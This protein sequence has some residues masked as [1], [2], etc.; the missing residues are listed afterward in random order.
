MLPRIILA[1]ATAAGI[2]FTASGSNSSATA[3][4]L[5]IKVHDA[6][7]NKPVEFCNIIAKNLPI[8]AL[9][10]EWGCAV[11]KAEPTTLC[12]TLLV[13]SVG[14]EKLM[15]ALTPETVNIDTLRIYLRP[16][17]YPLHEVT[18]KP[19]RKTKV[20]KKGKRHDGG[21]FM[22]QFKVSRGDC[23][24]W[25]AGTKGK[26]TWLTSIQ[27]QSW[28]YPDSSKRS[29]TDSEAAA[30][31][32]TGI[33]PLEQR[34]RMR[35]NIYDASTKSTKSSGIER[36]DYTN[37][38]HK[39]IIISYTKEQVIDNL[40]TYT[41]PEPILLPEKAL[42][43]IEILDEIPTD[44]MIIFK[45]NMFGRGIIFRNVNEKIWTKIPL[46]TPFTLIFLE[47]KL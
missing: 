17:E 41:L 31:G 45:N 44:E 34:M 15:V 26:R 42:V 23:F 35:V 7:T 37:I 6:E 3:D 39:P 12:D 43:E 38:L 25:E 22:G 2:A 9:A 16:K 8:G 19:A 30:K 40:F 10:D 21:L 14:Y 47:E 18:V 5:R 32:R 33:H 24:A 29:E 20:L 13:S 11:M 28:Q 1:A 27:M 46:A 4:S 36:W